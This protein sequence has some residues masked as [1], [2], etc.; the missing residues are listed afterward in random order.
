MKELQMSGWIVQVMSLT[1]NYGIRS[2]GSNIFTSYSHTW[3]IN[4]LQRYEVFFLI[5]QFKEQKNYSILFFISQTSSQL[6][7]MVSQCS[8]HSEQINIS[9]SVGAL[10]QSDSFHPS[11]SNSFIPLCFETSIQII[12]RGSM[13]FW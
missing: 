1:D 9:V 13:F 11:H 4:P 8:P 2:I 3:T 10:Q 12:P 6:S 7:H 5:Q